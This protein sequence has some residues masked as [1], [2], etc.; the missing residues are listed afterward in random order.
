[1]LQGVDLTEALP[2]LQEADPVPVPV[3][4][5][6]DVSI[7][8]QLRQSRLLPGSLG[9]HLGFHQYSVP[10]VYG[11]GLYLRFYSSMA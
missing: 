2:H 7:H 6:A 11:G 8:S 4:A 9:F 1:M 3:G 5:P 10:P